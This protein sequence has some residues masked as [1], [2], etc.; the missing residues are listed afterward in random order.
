MSEQ[1]GPPPQKSL[2]GWF[3]LFGS[4]SLAVVGALVGYWSPRPSDLNVVSGAIY[5]L[6]L[7]AI[8]GVI[9]DR[10]RKSK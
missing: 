6:L 10:Q 3:V 4:V 2:L 7:G 5:G 9:A 8:A 1:H